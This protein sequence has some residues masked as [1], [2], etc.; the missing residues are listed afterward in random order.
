MLG[1]SVDGSIVFDSFKI[2][3]L[4]FPEFL[5]VKILKR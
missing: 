2:A 4:S 5:A 3:I 1:S